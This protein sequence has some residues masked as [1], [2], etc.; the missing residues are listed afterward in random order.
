MSKFNIDFS[1][2]ASWCSNLKMRA[3]EVLDNIIEKKY[4][5]R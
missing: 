1:I 4:F 5:G 3:I 2:S